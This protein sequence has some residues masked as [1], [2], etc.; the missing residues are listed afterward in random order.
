MPECLKPEINE[1]A[2]Y[3]Q[4]TKTFQIIVINTENQSGLVGKSS[5]DYIRKG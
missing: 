2:S 4:F 3:T 1:N 5:V